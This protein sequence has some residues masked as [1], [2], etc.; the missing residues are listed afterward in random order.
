MSIN[1]VLVEPEIPQNTG[2]IA[3][4]CAAT[5]C[6]L[7]LVKPLGFS[8]E[9]KYLKRAGLDYWSLVEIKYHDNLDA[10][11]DMY[12]EGKFFLSTTKA[13]NKYTDLKYEKDCFILFGK[14]TAGLPKDL[15]LKNP[16]E[17]IRVPMI[18]EARSL[19]LSNSVAIVVYEA[20]RQIGFPNMI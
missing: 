18:D 16:D 4:T 11:F 20:L 15:L 5:G 14:E 19:N 12:R 10:F 9:D 17:C 2:N 8:V 13:K 6:K 7:H 1:I 3:R